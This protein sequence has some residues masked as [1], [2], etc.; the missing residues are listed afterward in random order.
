MEDT[1]NLRYELKMVTEDAV[2]LQVNSWL[3]VHPWA[4]HGTYPSRQVNNIYFDTPGLDSYNDHIEGSG[5]RRKLRYRWY[6]TDLRHA[7]GQVEVKNKKNNLGWKIVQKVDQ[8]LDL[9]EMNWN[10]VSQALRQNSDGVVRELLEVS[11]P[12]IINTYDR[13]YFVSADGLVRSTIDYNL[14]GYEQWLNARPNLNF[15]VP[16]RK[17]TIL[18][19]KSDSQ[20][21]KVLAEGFARFPIRLAP[22]SKYLGVMNA[23]VDR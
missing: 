8:P 6:G 9:V 3:R 13:D 18:E 23:L 2:R 17:L 21:G 4:F 12:I 11:R 22:Y 5:L 10:D 20:N 19:F 7:C 1:P 16:Y 14:C 15:K